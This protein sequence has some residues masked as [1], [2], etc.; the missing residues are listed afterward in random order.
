M[1]VKLFCAVAAV[2]TFAFLLSTPLA[3]QW[4]DFKTP[5]IPRTPD[6]KPDLSAPVPHTADGKP[7][8]SAQRPKRQ[9]APS[10]KR[11]DRVR[12]K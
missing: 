3:A 2:T 5:G 11:R 12:L 10:Q 1:K 7:D 6:G 9:S 8:L 4:F